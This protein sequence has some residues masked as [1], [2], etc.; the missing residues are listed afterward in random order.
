MAVGEFHKMY[1]HLIEQA[2]GLNFSNILINSIRIIFGKLEYSKMWIKIILSN[3]KQL[4]LIIQ[5]ILV[6]LMILI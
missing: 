5:S 1:V 6:L 3:I 2:L 4:I